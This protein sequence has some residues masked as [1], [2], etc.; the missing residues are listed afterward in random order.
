MMGSLEPGI[1]LYGADGVTSSQAQMACDLACMPLN[2]SVFTVFLD[3]RACGEDKA[4]ESL[5][6]L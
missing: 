5:R 6:R 3:C 4:G 2:L 1:G